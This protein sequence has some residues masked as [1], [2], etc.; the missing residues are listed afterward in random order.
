MDMDATIEG[1]EL[2]FLRN[3]TKFNNIYC[4]K[5]L[6]CDTIYIWKTQLNIAKRTHKL[7]TR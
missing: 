2:N 4:K 5:M 1:L 7:K 6:L 3:S